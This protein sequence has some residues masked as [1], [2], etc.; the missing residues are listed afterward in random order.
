MDGAVGKHGGG[1]EKVIAAMVEGAAKAALAGAAPSEGFDIDRFGRELMAAKDPAALL[2]SFVVQTRSDEGASALE[3]RLAERLGEAGIF[4]DEGR[5]PGLRVVRPRTSG[6]FYLRIEDAELPYL[7]KLRVLGVEAALNGAL[8]CSALLDDPRGA[9]MEEIV[10]T[11]Q[12]VARSVAQQAQTPVLDPEELGCGGEWADR[13]AIAAGIECLRL[14]YR[15]SARFRVNAREGEAAIEV[16]LVPPRLMPAKA[17]V[18]GLG[19]V[20]ASDAM[21][22]RAATDYNLR[23]LVLLCA[24]VFNNTPDLHRV[25]ISGVVDTATSHACYCS[26][27]LEREDLEGIDLARAE[28][29]SLMRFLCASMD[30]SDGTLAPVAQGFSMDEERFCP[31]GRYRT[32]E[33]SDE[34]LSSASAAAN[35]GCR[36]V[37]G[38]SVR[39]DAARAEVA[40]KASAALGPS[41]EENVRS[42]LEIARE[43]GDPDVIAASREVARRLIEGEIDESDPEAV[44]ESFKAASALRQTVADAQKKLFAGDAEGC[45]AVVAEA[46]AP[47]E[48]DSRYR[49]DAGTRW[50]LFD[51]YADRVIYN[52]LFADDCPEVRLVPRAYFDALQLL[53]ASDLL[54]ERPEAACDL[55][56]Q[57][58]HMAP[59]STQA[60]LNYSHCLLELGRVEE[61]SE[62]CCRMLRCASDPQSIGFGYITM[63]QLQWKLGNMVASQAC[64]Q[65]ASRMLPGGIVDAARQIAS[66]LGAENSESLSDERVAEALAARGIPLAPSE[67]VLQ[68]LEEGAAAAIDENLFRP[69]REM[70][71]LLT[72]LTRDDIDHGILRSLEDEPDF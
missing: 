35:L 6:L 10:R 3:R 51:G 23:V 12:R 34:R 70:L 66:L 72:A 21:R 47:I 14:P 17:Y 68:V 11:E 46:L 38:L 26:A 71:Y 1:I 41:T 62:E 30:E 60:A 18:D 27:A 25:W 61:A 32:V 31:K 42:V 36:Y 4:E 44:E 49:D 58:A 8:L 28:P 13:K 5:L 50:R 37:H 63:A 43:S 48:A 52:R 33:L 55:A 65:M 9:S 53:S 40:R 22:R 2:E 45:A 19:I 29:V 16:E 56:R 67:E 7:A 57:A 20:P 69:G 54:L 39:E 24:Y 64:Y 15:L 59:L